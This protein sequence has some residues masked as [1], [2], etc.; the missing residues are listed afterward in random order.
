MLKIGATGSLFKSFVIEQME[1]YK[2]KVELEALID[3]QEITDWYNEIQAGLGGR[4][5]RIT[6]DHINLHKY[7]TGN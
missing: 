3:I 4:F 2:V 5:Q 1:K 6:I 7:K